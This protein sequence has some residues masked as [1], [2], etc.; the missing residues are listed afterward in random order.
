M[1]EIYLFNP[2]SNAEDDD[3]KVAC[4][5]LYLANKARGKERQVPKVIDYKESCVETR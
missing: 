3:R 1:S 4:Q 5:N 2:F